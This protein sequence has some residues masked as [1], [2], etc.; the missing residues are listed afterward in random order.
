MKKWTLGFVTIAVISCI[1][2]SC[3]KTKSAQELLKEERRAIE[4]FI[5]TNNLVVLRD[6]PKNGIFAKNEY[7]R[8]DEGLFI[9][10]V[11]SGNGTR[12]QYRNDVSLRF[13][14]L[15]Y[16]KSTV[17]GDTTLYFP[18]N[19]YRP[20]S[21]IYLGR[22]SFIPYNYEVCQ[23]WVI[24]L[25]YVGEEAVV[26]LIVPSSIGTSGDN[27]SIRPVFYRNLRYTRFN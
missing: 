11:D 13:E 10:V 14:H 21:F 5:T 12:V 9:Q 23:A 19:P 1:S 6:Y 3:N 22:E 4:R 15:Q 24:P 25:S 20:F 16:I 27:E 17:Q 26:N 18:Y 7:Y 8:T 2:F